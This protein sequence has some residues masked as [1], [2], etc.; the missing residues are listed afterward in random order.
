MGWV[1]LAGMTLMGC[2]TAAIILAKM[3]GPDEEE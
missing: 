1:G 3:L 2:L